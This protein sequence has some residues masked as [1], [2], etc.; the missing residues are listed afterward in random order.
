M[1][2]KDWWRTDNL[3]GGGGVGWVWCCEGMPLSSNSKLGL[4]LLVAEASGSWWTELVSGRV[5][6]GGMFAAIVV[7]CSGGIISEVS[8]PVRYER[9]DGKCVWIREKEE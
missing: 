5:D 7:S 4:I 9:R 6:M 2:R 3:G 1:G 8:D